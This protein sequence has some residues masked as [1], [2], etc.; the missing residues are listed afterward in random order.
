MA[1]KIAP[2]CMHGGEPGL[3]EIWYMNQG[4][5]PPKCESQ[6]KCLFL[7]SRLQINHMVFA[8]EIRTLGSICSMYFHGLE[9]GWL[10]ASC[11]PESHHRESLDSSVQR[12]L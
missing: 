6:T 12:G 9:L 7:K 10:D 3:R 2:R 8:L 11:P 4:H 1:N 5:N